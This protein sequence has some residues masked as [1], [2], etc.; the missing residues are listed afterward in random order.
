MK[1]Y[2]MVRHGSLVIFNYVQTDSFTLPSSCIAIAFV[3]A[4]LS[5]HP[6]RLRHPRPLHHR[7][8]SHHLHHHRVAVT[9]ISPSS[10]S[11]PSSLASL[12]PLSLHHHRV[13]TPH[14]PRHP[15]L[16]IAV[17]LGCNYRC[18]LRARLRSHERSVL[19]L[20]LAHPC[21]ALVYKHTRKGCRIGY[22]W[23]NLMVLHNINI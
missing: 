11:S 16:H 14:R 15:R 23:R 10:P 19:Q 5:A 13:P 17:S 1:R 4:L 20:T 12:P 21:L 18:K 7:R 9:L 3:V 8:H 22:R 6:H 2:H